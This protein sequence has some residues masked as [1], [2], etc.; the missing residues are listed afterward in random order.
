[1]IILSLLYDSADLSSAG[2]PKTGTKPH[3]PDM[4]TKHTETQ[5]VSIL[6]RKALKSESFAKIS[7]LFSSER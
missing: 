3:K 7:T 6:K 4:R 5:T 2:F 1:M